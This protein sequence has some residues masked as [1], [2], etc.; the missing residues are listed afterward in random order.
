MHA[1]WY[2]SSWLLFQ[3]SVVGRRDSGTHFIPPLIKEQ[4]K[5]RDTLF[6]KGRRGFSCHMVITEFTIILMSIKYPEQCRCMV[7]RLWQGYGRSEGS[8][9]SAPECAIFRKWIICYHLP[10]S[11]ACILI[12]LWAPPGQLWW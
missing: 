4:E 12:G 11:S 2:L 10:A 7:M 9:W 1:I 8:K 6:S 3:Y 5:W